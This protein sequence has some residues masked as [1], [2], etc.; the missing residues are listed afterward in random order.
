MERQRGAPSGPDTVSVLLATASAT[1]MALHLKRRE[2]LLHE[3]GRRARVGAAPGTN[4]REVKGD[5]GSPFKTTADLGRELGFG[6]R[7]TQ[8]KLQ[9]GKNLAPETVEVVSGTPIANSRKDYPYSGHPFPIGEVVSGTETR[10]IPTRRYPRG[11]DRL[12][13]LFTW[14]WRKFRRGGLARRGSIKMIQA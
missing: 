8:R 5:P 13:P 11:T 12:Y 9:T 14:D 7:E 6:K 2:E 3:R 10:G 4:N 1:S